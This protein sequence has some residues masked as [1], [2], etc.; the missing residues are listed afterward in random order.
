MNFRR[1]ELSHF[2]DSIEWLATEES[3][4]WFDKAVLFLSK[5]HYGL[6]S[7]ELRNVERR[8]NETEGFDRWLADRCDGTLACVAFSGDCVFKTNVEFLLANWRDI[9]CPSRDDGILLSFDRFWVAF[10]CHEDE[11]E[12]GD[13]PTAIVE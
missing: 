5:T 10:Y 13:R 6:N 12:I 11:I 7:S 4:T 1:D 8:E 9:F 3:R 2:G